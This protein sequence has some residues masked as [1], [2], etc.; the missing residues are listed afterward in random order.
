M[1]FA[2]FLAFAAIAGITMSAE[3]P[4]KE[5]EPAVAAQAEVSPAEAAAK[6]ITRVLP[7]Q[8]SRFLCETIPQ[9]NGS[10]VFEIEA[11]DGKI[12]LRGNNGISIAMAFNWYLR[13]TA[14]TNF[15][16]QAAAPLEIQGE[17]PLPVTKVRQTC[18]AKERFFLNYCTYGYTMPWW[19]WEQ[20]QRFVD[21]MAMNG[22]NRPL[23]QAG[24]EAVWLEVWK[25]Y[26][27]TDE[28]VRTYFGSP[29]HL[30]WHRMAN[31]DKWDRPLPASYIEGQMKL[32][33]CVC[34]PE[35]H[36]GFATLASTRRLVKVQF[37]LNL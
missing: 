1:K 19:G 31:H 18:A 12:V 2:V 14:K 37:G 32:Q 15:D 16:W 5:N 9:E 28:Q 21:W 34:D 22:I 7:G 29:A 10:D 11:K 17:L 25:S 26:G 35:S 23:L 4:A 6:L 3:T 33:K 30:P 20:W 8:S 24:T 13:Y 36:F 27:L